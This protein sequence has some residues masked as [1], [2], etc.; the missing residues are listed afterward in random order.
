LIESFT[1]LGPPYYT[2]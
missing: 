2:S 1:L